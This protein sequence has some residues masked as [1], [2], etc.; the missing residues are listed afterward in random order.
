[1][2]DAT[3][4]THPPIK[5]DKPWRV[6]RYGLR[7][8]HPIREFRHRWTARL[9]RLIKF[10]GVADSYGVEPAYDWDGEATIAEWLA[11]VLLHIV[12]GMEMREHEGPLRKLTASHATAALDTVPEHIL[13]AARIDRSQPL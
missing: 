11:E 9:Y 1:M 10:F 5:A 7:H 3:P 4:H 2:S 12:W 6:V 13:R 8:T